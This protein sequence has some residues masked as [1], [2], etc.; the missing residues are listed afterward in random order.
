MLIKIIKIQ[1]PGF[2][3]I[4][5]QK[6]EKH[7]DRC[8]FKSLKAAVISQENFEL[9]KRIIQL[10]LGC[11]CLIFFLEVL[12]PITLSVFPRF[13][14]ALASPN[15]NQKNLNNYPFFHFF[16]K[17]VKITFIGSTSSDEKVSST[18]LNRF[19]SVSFKSFGLCSFTIF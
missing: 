4:F 11:H 18:N 13:P 2:H 17:C 1:N 15:L 19:K 7:L 5:R 3:S 10:F 9:K 14:D 8:F 16:S 12:S 6:N